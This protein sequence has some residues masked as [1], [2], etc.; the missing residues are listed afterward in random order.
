[1][2]YNYVRICSQNVQRNFGYVD[3]L[4]EEKKDLFDIL[5]LQEPPWNTIRRTF[6]TSNVA[7]DAVM[8]PPVHPDW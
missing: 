5:F 3:S 4:L 7:G 2:D 1:M 8:G 6:S